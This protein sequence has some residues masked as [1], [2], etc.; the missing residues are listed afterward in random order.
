[1]SVE[2]YAKNYDDFPM[3]PDQPPL[4]PADEIIYC[5]EFYL[6]EGLVSRGRARS[7]GIEAAFQQ[8]ARQGF[9]GA[10]YASYALAEYRDLDGV[11]RHR[12][13]ENRFAG[14]LEG[15]YDPGGA[16]R[17]S[18]RWVYAGGRPYTPFD[19]E[20][21]R[22]M[23]SG[24]FDTTRINEARLPDYHVLNVRAE[25]RFRILGGE[26]NVYASIWNVYDRR[27]IYYYTWDREEE[28]RVAVYQWGFLPILGIEVKL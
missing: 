11:W 22:S 14:G 19:I 6:H 8:K 28:R 27:N 15:G 16:W 12:V 2:A 1:V 25:R 20:K 10:V 23:G 3:D 18:A 24:V 13:V 4:F 26:I 7:Y 5:G 17:V 21:S 9:F